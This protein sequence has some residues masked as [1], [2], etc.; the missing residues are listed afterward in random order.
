MMEETEY[1]RKEPGITFPPMKTGTT[2]VNKVREK[3]SPVNSSSNAESGYSKNY[4]NED[5]I[6]LISALIHTRLTEL[7]PEMIT[8]RNK[9]G[10][11]PV[12]LGDTDSYYEDFETNNLPKGEKGKIG[13]THSDELSALLKNSTKN[14][15]N[16]QAVG[17]KRPITNDDGGNN[18]PAKVPYC[19]NPVSDLEVDLEILN[20]VDQEHQI[21]QKLGDAISE[22]LAS[23]IKKHWSYEPEK[24]GNIEKLHEKLLIP[25][26]CGE[27]CTH[28]LNREIFCNNSIPDWVKED[29]K[30]IFNLIMGE[31]MPPT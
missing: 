9:N 21:L 2:N 27:I 1:S 8:T 4:H 16:G 26:N 28:K 14:N 10:D 19:Q 15:N 18:T 11:Q 22:R 23:V 5:L 3:I 12:S 25:Q 20:Q 13:D 17:Q 24:F 7:R 29:D 6:N 30:N 31:R